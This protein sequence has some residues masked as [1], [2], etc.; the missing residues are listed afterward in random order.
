MQSPFGIRALTRA[1]RRNRA[2][3]RKTG[4]DHEREHEHDYDDAAKCWKKAG[5]LGGSRGGRGPG[6]RFVQARLTAIRGVLVNDSALGCLVDGRNH[7]LYVLRFR[8]RIGARNAF[9]HLAQ[10]SKDTSIAERTHCCLTSAFGGGFCVSHWEN[11]ERGGSRTGERLSRRDA[12]LRGQGRIA[13]TTLRGQSEVVR[14]YWRVCR[15]SPL[16]FSRELLVLLPFR[17]RASVLRP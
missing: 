2:R 6:N 7:G 11:C 14:P 16:T 8:F 1:H 10:A 9:L 4:I 17:A 15:R 12:P 3:N 5:C 13:S